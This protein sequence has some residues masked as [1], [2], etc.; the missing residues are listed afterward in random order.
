MTNLSVP[1]VSLTRLSSEMQREILSE[2]IMDEID[3]LDEQGVTYQGD[4]T[5]D[6]L[7]DL[8]GSLITRQT[9]AKSVTL[10]TKAGKYAATLLSLDGN[11]AA[12]KAESSAVDEPDPKLDNF[13]N[14]YDAKTTKEDPQPGV[15]PEEFRKAVMSRKLKDDELADMEARVVW[16]DEG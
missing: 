10:R 11:E 13:L 3:R 4:Y 15:T 7:F 16:G 6:E 12:A 2:R 9:D 5:R 14:D 1:S 8:H